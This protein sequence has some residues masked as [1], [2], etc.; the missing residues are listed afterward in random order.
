M[1]SEG[2][3]T[4]FGADIGAPPDDKAK[5]GRANRKGYP[6]LYCAEEEATAVAEVRPARGLFVSVAKVQI[7]RPLRILDLVKGHPP[8]NPFE[9]SPYLYSHLAYDV[10]L[11]DLLDSFG[12]ELAGPLRR[13][14][15]PRDYLPCQRLSELVHGFGFDGIRYPSAMN[16]GGANVVLFDPSV[17]TILNSKLVEVRNLKIEYIERPP[18][19]WPRFV[20]KPYF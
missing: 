8:I 12:N 19:S 13:T 15:D 16:S 7:D 4:I 9:E 5:P 3:Q 17:A 2:S 1:R 14:D 6:V 18:S 11:L 20:S 10:E